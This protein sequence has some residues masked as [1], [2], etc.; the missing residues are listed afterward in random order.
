MIRLVRAF[1]RRDIAV[2]KDARGG[3]VRAVLTFALLLAGLFHLGLL[4]PPETL[5]RAGGQGEFLPFAL[6]GVA[7][8]TLCGAAGSAPRLAL[9]GERQRGTLEFLLLAPVR[10]AAWIAAGSIV[11]LAGGALRAA[12]FAAAALAAAPADPGRLALAALVAVAGAV[13]SCAWGLVT[14]SLDLRGQRAAL[15]PGVQALLG[16][17]L[18]PVDLFPLPLRAAAYALPLTHVAAG[19][20]AAIAGDAPAAALHLAALALLAA[21]GSAAGGILLSRTLR[22][23]RVTGDF[24]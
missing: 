10:P 6:L 15:G 5:R 8:L 7:A 19:T 24:G 17:V 3:P 1:L 16:G 20:R 21:V 13:A 18:F 22:R 2:R 4:V 14:A 9:Q 11:P 12:V 23:L